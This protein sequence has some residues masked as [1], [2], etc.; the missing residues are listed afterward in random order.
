MVRVGQA[1]GEPIFPE[2]SNFSMDVS[3]LNFTLINVTATAAV[4]DLLYKCA[5]FN[6]TLE[7]CVDKCADG[8]ED[9][10]CPV[11]AE[12]LWT[13]FGNVT[14]GQNFTFLL[15]NATD[16]GFGIFS[17]GQHEGE[18]STVS[19]TP[20]AIVQVNFTPV[21]LQ[22][23]LLGY[24]ETQGATLGSA[25]RPSLVLNATEVIGNISLQPDTSR[26]SNPPGDYAPFFTHALKNMT[27]L[28]Q[29]LSI[30][31]ASQN[32]TGN[33][34]FIKRARAITLDI[35]DGDAA[36]NAS[37]D[38][39]TALAPA[40]TFLPMANVS[41]TPKTNASLL[42]LASA[43]LAPNSATQSVLA[44][45][46]HNGT[47][48]AFT[49]QEGEVPQDVRPF[50]A[51]LFVNATA[52]VTQNFTIQAQSETTATKEIRNA[53][54]TVVPLSD[55]FFNQSEGQ[56]TTTGTAFINKTNLTFSLASASTV[57][58]VA[59]ADV[60][61]SSATNGNFLGA[62][63]FMDGLAV[64]NMTMGASDATDDFSF[65]TVQLTN[66]T[67]GVHIARLAFR[68]DAGSAGVVNMRRARITVIPLVNNAP[69][70]ENLTLVSDSGN[71]LTSDNL[72][73][74]FSSFDLDG[75]NVKNVTNWFRNDESYLTLNMPFEG[76]SNQTFTRDYTPF[77]RN[78][79]VDNATYLPRGGFDGFGAYGFD[80][81]L[82]SN[83][84][85]RGIPNQSVNRTTGSVEVWANPGNVTAPQMLV[86]AGDAAGNGYG[87]NQEW[88]LGIQHFNLSLNLT[89]FTFWYGDND[90]GGVPVAQL[91]SSENFTQ[92]FSQNLSPGQY[93][94]VVVTWDLVNL[95]RTRMYINGTLVN[96][97]N[98]TGDP[99][100]NTTAWQ[101]DLLIGRPQ[102]SGTPARF[103]NGTLD[104]ARLWNRALT[105]EQVFAL[106][107]NRTRV[108]VANETEQ[109][110]VWGAC[111]TPNDRLVDGTT[112]C[113]NNVTIAA[114]DIDIFVN[115]SEIF[116]NVSHPRE[117]ENT[118][119]NATIRNL[120]SATATTVL[121]MFWDNT[122]TG[123]PFQINGNITI[124]SIPGGGAVVVNVTYI[125]IIGNRTI[126]VAADP[127]NTITETNEGNN[128]ATAQLNVQAWT[129][130]FG[131]SRANLTLDA[132]LENR[133]HFT[134]NHSDAG[135]VY[136]FD[137][138]SNFSVTALQALGRN[139][140]NGTAVNDFGEADVNLN[141]TGFNDS[142]VV[143]FTGNSNSTPN[144]TR[145]LTLFGRLVGQVPVL[146][147]TNTG[148]FITGI[149]WDTGD[150]TNGQ[151]DLTDR[152]DV[153]FVGN[154]NLSKAG[155]SGN[156]IDYE[157]R[158]PT[159]LRQ[160][161]PPNN[162]T[163]F[164]TELG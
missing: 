89:G 23:L 1:I 45:L 94:H 163:A 140:T 17:S 4:G 57:L 72:T 162:Q 91:G 24:A 50:M 159:L 100:Y 75:D 37:A 58:V 84:Y 139:T 138:D 5:N 105:E 11:Q 86:W 157:V 69:V 148:T 70:V 88:H 19:T 125:T 16:P 158:V 39:F 9:G 85:I 153:I 136:F 104:E 31:L 42:V 12:G 108:I 117:T 130:F 48:V 79:T 62:H 83:G 27:S 156:P 35:R 15:T 46:L 20:A 38:N 34:S 36:T 152:E 78:G 137:T 76:G 68:R 128:N 114:A 13:L 52:N 47:E 112:Q 141:M 111:V 63:L 97:D 67:A 7:Q 73:L 151:Y 133:S 142:V 33:V 115:A 6:R 25:V 144:Q 103:Y 90:D 30:M 74:N 147:S 44:R 99:L 150:D 77:G 55:V 116:F 49:E 3:E 59:S 145:N 135:F 143:L 109:G 56:S 92:L 95:N 71:N 113:S 18:T 121:V 106:A 29:N 8:T 155:A 51:H 134:W 149:L 132:I 110:D 119:I 161:R 82:A 43:E 41:Y 87:A 120:G 127:A 64:G 126:L 81:M 102:N 129:I 96:E 118:T 22:V 146:N 60:N 61:I 122:T 98:T 66:L 10:D 26:T 2:L 154:I 65:F 21:Q 164:I 54:V 101:D 14:I 160:Y 124:G 80:G 107:N 53:R 32:G 93:Y 123:M 28:P 40:G 131:N